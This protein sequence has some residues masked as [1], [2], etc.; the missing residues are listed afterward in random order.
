MTYM[1]LNIFHHLLQD[2]HQYYTWT[3]TTG[4]AEWYWQELADDAKHHKLSNSPGGYDVSAQLTIATVKTH[5]SLGLALLLL[6]H[7]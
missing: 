6:Y 7:D 1:Y 3:K 2:F 4:G 5:P